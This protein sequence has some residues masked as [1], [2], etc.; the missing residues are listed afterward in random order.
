M[1]KFFIYFSIISTTIL[2]L[3]IWLL[4]FCLLLNLFP[5]SAYEWLRINLPMVSDWCNTIK[6]GFTNIQT[7]AF[8]VLLGSGLLLIILFGI[9][10]PLIKIKAIRKYMLWLIIPLYSIGFSGTAISL[11]LL[12]INL[13]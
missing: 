8:Y 3:I 4:G 2:A 5:S 13:L 7:I 10:Y 11:I 1:K 9:Q 6:N 12:F